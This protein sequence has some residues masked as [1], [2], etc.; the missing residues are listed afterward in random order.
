MRD[1]GEIWVV[2]LQ[3]VLHLNLVIER[4][5]TK[6]IDSLSIG[7]I[8]KTF[9]KLANK[10]LYPDTFASFVPNTKSNKRIQMQELCNSNM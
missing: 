9:L 8:K 6:K 2:S 1:I 4:N 10:G 3:A 5:T 7:F